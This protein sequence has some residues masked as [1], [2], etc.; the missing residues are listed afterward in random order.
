MEIPAGA[1]DAQEQG[2]RRSM[3]SFDN[4]WEEIHATQEWG[5]YPSES[6]I[7]FVARNYYQRNRAEVKILDFGC[8]GGSH[9]W[10]LAR[11]GFDTYAFDGSP[12][13]I[14]RVNKK[15]EAEGLRADVRVRDALELD[16]EDG[17]F[18]CV[19]DSA[20]VYAN[21]YENIIA[22]YQKI[23]NLLKPG[24]KLFSISFTTGTTGFGSGE[25]IEQHTFCD[26][27]EG[28]LSGRGTTHFFEEGEL[29]GIL[30]R[31]GFREIV[32]D[33]IRFTDRG[34]VVEQFLVQG[35]K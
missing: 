28:S 32:V 14:D 21:T 16:Y 24:G 17:V 3:K 13:A 27:T 18:D 1:E 7:R 30:T 29:R 33:Q 2:K 5:Q 10:Y 26:I 20:V 11:E 34:S 19:I 22:M 15:L 12:S 9:T 23:Y 6:V 31:I 8:G 4:T 25:E 35:E